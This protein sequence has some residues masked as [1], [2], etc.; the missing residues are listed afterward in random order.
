MF[1]ETHLNNRQKKE[2][3]Q[4]TSSLHLRDGI[5]Y[6][7]NTLNS[8]KANISNPWPQGASLHVLAEIAASSKIGNPLL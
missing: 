7:F 6:I 5:K 1:S 4:T 2:E 3:K 8:L